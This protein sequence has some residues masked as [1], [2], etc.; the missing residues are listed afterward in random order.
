ME[1]IG[2]EVEIMKMIHQ[3]HVVQLREVYE[4]PEKI[5]LIMEYCN[6]GELVKKVQMTNSIEEKDVKLVIKRLAGAMGYLHD[7][8]IVHRDIKPENILLSTQDPNDPYNIKVSDF[9]LAAFT[10]GGKLMEN[11]CG[12]PFYMAPE[13]VS[14][15]GYSHSC[16]IWSIGIML[17]LLL[18]K[19]T[20]EAEQTLRDM[21]L[22]SKLDFQ[23]EIWNDVT[24]SAKNLLERMLQVDPAQR[25]AAKEI[26]NHPW[27]TGEKQESQ[28]VLEMMKSYKAEQRW[29]KAIFVVCA[30]SRFRKGIKAKSLD[31][32]TMGS[33]ESELLSIPVEP[34]VRR[35]SMITP[36]FHRTASNGTRYTQRLSKPPTTKITSSSHTTNPLHR[37]NTNISTSGSNVSPSRISSENLSP[38]LSNAPSSK[39]PRSPKVQSPNNTISRSP[40]LSQ[41]K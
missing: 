25:I 23:H 15:Q 33:L 38:L 14:G 12:T 4:T 41:R 21:V 30:M 1:Q 27:V 20:K 35:N 24:A 36:G 19:Y 2:R 31:T 22:H 10:G 40:S 37:S 32:I 16:D 39:S 6:G 11:V 34:T 28:N 26:L 7:H 9:G 3:K 5:Y 18:T 17:A 8:G 13:V 29:K